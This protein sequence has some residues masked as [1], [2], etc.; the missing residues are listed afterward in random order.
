MNLKK[1]SHSFVST[2]IIISL[3]LL[4]AILG[5]PCLFLPRAY[6]AKLIHSW[7][8]LML[9]LFKRLDGL[10]WEIIGKENIPSGPFIV[11]SKHQSIWDTIF[12]T[13]LFPDS[14]MVLKRMII[15]IPF[16]G[17]HAMKVG[18]IWL[19]RGAHSK[20]IRKLVK[21]GKSCSV[22]E[23]PIVIFPEGTRSPVGEKTPY[24]SGVA[25]LYKF[26]KIPCI[27]V[28]LNSGVYWKT[29]GLDRNPGKITV[30][31][32][33]QI[34]PGLNRKDFEKKLENTIETE[35]NLLIG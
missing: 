23:R 4:I 21:Q 31:F 8:R 5:S 3:T 7:S 30:K 35:T 28:A 11:A 1:T 10:D 33:P 6:T 15:F 20:S 9:V 24:K 27:P 34:P 17:W 26:L 22:S 32:M 19:D 29:K 16:Y 18:M 25:A 14:A 2:A 13:A 12:F